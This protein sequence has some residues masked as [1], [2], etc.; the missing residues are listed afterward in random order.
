MASII[1]QRSPVV[2]ASMPVSVDINWYAI[3]IRQTSNVEFFQHELKIATAELLERYAAKDWKANAKSDSLSAL[4]ERNAAA[5][6]AVIVPTT[7]RVTQKKQMAR[8][9]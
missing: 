2:L 7:V 8:A 5:N 6:A 4:L 9:E 3:S 1:F